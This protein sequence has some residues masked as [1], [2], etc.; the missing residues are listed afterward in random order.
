MGTLWVLAFHNK[1]SI[2]DSPPSKYDRLYFNNSLTC[3][4]TSGK[5]KLLSALKD[6]KYLRVIQN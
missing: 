6:I 3:W 4:Q 2:C 5:L 1:R